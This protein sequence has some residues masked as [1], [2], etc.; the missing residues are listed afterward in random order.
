MDQRAERTDGNADPPNC[1]I[2]AV[3][4]IQ[5]PPQPDADKT[6]QLVAEKHDAI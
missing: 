1:G 2:A 4:I 6:A 5:P 3:N